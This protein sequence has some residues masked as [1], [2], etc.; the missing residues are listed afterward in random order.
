MR[1]LKAERKPRG[2][3]RAKE[4]RRSSTGS[5]ILPDRLNFGRRK[6]KK[7]PLAKMIGDLRGYFT[8]RRPMLLLTFVLMVLTGIFAL[9]AG[10][11][12]SR[13]IGAANNGVNSVIADS[14]FAVSAI[15]IS[16]EGHTSPQ[17][18]YAALG[19]APGQ[20]IFSA[21]LWR[22][23]AKLMQLDWVANADVRRRYPDDI[24]VTIAEK[25]P[26]ALWKSAN[27]FYVI[28]RSGRTI[29]NENLEQFARLPVLAG[30][31]APAKGAQIV[32]A[33]AAHRAVAARVRAMER[34][35]DRRWN[36]VL[37]DGVIVKL[38][39]TGWQK[40]LDVLEHLIVD[41]AILERDIQEIDL[42]APDNFIFILKNGQ[43]QRAM[44]EKA[45]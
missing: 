38:P 3:K 27:G 20:T 39:E 2:R 7:N 6:G 17:S 32:D 4:A 36:L 11:Y 16:G 40:Q 35:S 33:I 24:A 41:K 31:G 12:V 10:G 19:F 22:A 42:R 37:D 18:I 13:A 44:R 23:R 8:L 34:V 28:E 43:E 15:H 14:G 30:A 29:T 1:S 5:R 9:F 26:F 25:K 21:D 45:T